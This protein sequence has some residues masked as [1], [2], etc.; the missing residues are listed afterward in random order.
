MAQ[1]TL[2]IT[3]VRIQNYR[4][5]VD[6]QF[7]TDRLNLF[8]GLNDVGK[9]N[10]LRALDL[11]F[12]GRTAASPFV[13]DRDFCKYTKTSANKAKESRVTLNLKLPASY[14]AAEIH[15]KKVWRLNGEYELGTELFHVDKTPLKARSR[16][17]A[18]LNAIRFE[19]VPAVK[20][21][22]YFE[23]LL[24]SLHDVL[25][26]TVAD[27]IRSAS[28]G[29]TSTINDKTRS[30]LD[31]IEMKL[32]IKSTIELP[33]DLRE[34]FSRLEFQSQGKMAIALGQRGDGVKA[35]H[36]PILLH[37]LAQQSRSW[38][39]KGSPQSQTIWGFEEPENN[40]EMSKAA[41]LAREFVE[42]SKEIQIFATTHS[43]AFY[44]LG[45][46][47]LET[48]IF[49]VTGTG[50]DGDTIVKPVKPGDLEAVDEHVGILPI[51]A[52]SFARAVAE[53]DKSMAMLSEVKKLDRPTVF[54]EGEIDALVLDKAFKL[55][56]PNL[57]DQV[58]IRSTTS[59]GANWVKD[60]LISWAHGRVAHKALGIC[61]LDEAGTQARQDVHNNPR[62]ET[63]N[64]SSR[65]EG[66]NE[67]IRVFQLH[68][69]PALVPI[70]QKG[71][72]LPIALEELFPISIW[73]HAE[74]QNWL[75]E[76]S[77]IVRL[78]NF[79]ALGTTFE[80][81]CQNKGATDE[82]LFLLTKCFPM[83]A[84]EKFA[85]YVCKLSGK[86]CSEAF[87]AFEH[88]TRKVEQFFRINTSQTVTGSM[89]ARKQ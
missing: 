50:A 15:W 42:Y 7:K 13:F 45:T 52:P 10:I 87:A 85:K 37:Y 30:A 82:E 38:R 32:G 24:K 60:M 43:P 73:R 64:H 81:Y 63:A 89:P 23:T 78:N 36:I 84:K 44:S 86:S 70:F 26:D 14:D 39:V 80:N 34:L 8:V 29:F 35:R 22:D 83:E 75:V 4:S 79:A 55:F 57:L 61:D 41:D 9:S 5:I 76:R 54:V 49:L 66:N 48:S 25:V 21:I 46:N 3:S 11:F 56:S 2:Q 69:P 62:V 47:V 59:A 6:E 72:T 1:E 28:G 58:L 27:E 40:L 53:R 88:L 16:V 77:D 31:E 20:G 17:P 12:N 67:H 71:L 68:K 19:Y 74:Q 51:I 33:S 65:K 18:L